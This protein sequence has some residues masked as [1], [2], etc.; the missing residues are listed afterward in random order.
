M[1]DSRDVDRNCSS[2]DTMVNIE[3]LMLFV[4]DVINNI[5]TSKQEKTENLTL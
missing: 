3:C 2:F 5:F 1:I 4:V